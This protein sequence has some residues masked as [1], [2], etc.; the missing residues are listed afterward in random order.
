MEPAKAVRAMAVAP[1]ECDRLLAECVKA[2]DIDGVASLY[3]AEALY[4]R[5]DGTV[6]TGRPAIRELLQSITNASTEIKMNIIRVV[7]LDGIA[8]IYNDWT[9]TT[10]SADGGI[11]ESTGKAIEIV[12]RQSDGRWLFAI[13]DPFGRSRS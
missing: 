11:R 3:E 13:D 1:E 2:R 8:L 5:R 6:V 7:T 4:V 12:R 10:V 9:A